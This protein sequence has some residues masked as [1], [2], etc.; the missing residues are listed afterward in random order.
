[1]VYKQFGLW[2]RKRTLAKIKLFKV[3]WLEMIIIFLE[4]NNKL[5][6]HKISKT[7]SESL[8]SKFLHQSSSG[9]NEMD[10]KVNRTIDNKINFSVKM[11]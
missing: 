8:G 5:F 3:K 4:L 10:L 11:F 2:I 1:M 9:L 7:G 6:R